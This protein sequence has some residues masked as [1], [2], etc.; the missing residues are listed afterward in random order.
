MK[1]IKKLSLLR[2]TSILAFGSISMVYAGGHGDE[3]IDGFSEQ[4]IY[5]ENYIINGEVL[6]WVYP[7]IN[8]IYCKRRWS[9]TSN[10][11]YDPGWIPV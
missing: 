5:G 6:E 9:L 10:C 11:W 7:Y 4:Y 3:I 8:G 1:R 2:I